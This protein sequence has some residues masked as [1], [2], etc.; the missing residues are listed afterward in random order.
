MERLDVFGLNVSNFFLTEIDQLYSET[1]RT[2][3]KIVLFGHSLGYIT[4]FKIYPSLYPVI[5]SFDV[6]VCDGTQF[7]WYCYLNGFKLKTVISIPDITNYTLEYANKMGLRVLLFGAKDQINKKACE[8]LQK[9]YPN[10]IITNG[11]NGYFKENE[12]ILIIDKIN[13]SK[14][15]ILL[16]GISSPIKEFFVHK[17]KDKLKANII[18]PCGGMIDVYSGFTKQSPNWVKK[19]GLATPFRIIQEPKRLLF[20]HTWMVYEILLK[21]IPIT[22]Y[23]KLILKSKKFNLVFKYLDK[24]N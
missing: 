2:E 20:L 14:P 6:L 15:Q 12:E 10:A 22:I 9:K 23:N 24:E 3:K 16:V 21:I 19:L 11:I 17:Y 8:N 13:E 7:N 4:L 18:I 5:N 1:I